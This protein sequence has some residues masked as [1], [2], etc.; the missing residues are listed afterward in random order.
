[1][2]WEAAYLTLTGDVVQQALTIA[3]ANADIAARQEVVDSD[4]SNAEML[5]KAFNAGGAIAADVQAAESQ[6]A[7][8]EST[9]PADRQILAVA[10]HRL[11]VLVGKTPA[12]WTAPDFSDIAGHLPTSLPVSLPSDMVRGR[13]DIL[14]AEAQLHAATAQIGVQTANLYPNI[15]LS[16]A[17]TQEALDPAKL[18]NYAA[19]AGDV[20]AGLTAPLFHGGELR[21]KKRQAED[22]AKAA[23]AAYQQTV[24]EAFAQVA[25]QL[26]AI[27]HDN[28]SY[29]D[30]VR[31][32]QAARTRLDMERNGFRLGG[33]SGL[34]VV[35]AERDWRNLRL[36]LVQQGSGRYADAARLLLATATVPAGL[37]EAQPA[38]P[39]RTPNSANGH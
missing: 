36:S 24:L 5:R 19:T 27:G 4:R 2:N 26:Q 7:E 28:E 30:Q 1:M 9:I 33:A 10:R 38:A 20:A 17:M 13:P 11:A 14:E 15:T 12:E 21:A 8:D 39:A 35:Q 31:G 25:D 23:Q 3:E 18:F 37:A 16:A 34:A 22:D 6:L 32:L 29:A